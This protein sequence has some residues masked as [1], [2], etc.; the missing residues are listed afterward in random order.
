MRDLIAKANVD[1]RFDL[2]SKYPSAFHGEDDE[3]EEDDEAFPD[4]QKTIWNKGLEMTSS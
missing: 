1:I 3:N 2:M 4:I